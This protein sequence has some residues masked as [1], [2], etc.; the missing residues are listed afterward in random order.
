MASFVPDQIW[1]AL[2]FLF[3]EFSKACYSEAIL[4]LF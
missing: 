3:D 4:R 2:E 1:H